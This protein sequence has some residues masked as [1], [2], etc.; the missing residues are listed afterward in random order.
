MMLAKGAGWLSHYEYFKKNF[1]QSDI[2]RVKESLS[3]E[4]RQELFSKTI[5]AVSWV[6]LKSIVNFLVKADKLLGKGD[7]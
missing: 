1:S 7:F 6:K 3:E 2:E 4:D 5:L